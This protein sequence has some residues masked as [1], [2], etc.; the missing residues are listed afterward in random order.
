M[1]AFERRDHHLVAV[2]LG[3][4]SPGARDGY[5]RRL[6][7]AGFKVAEADKG[8]LTMASLL[9]GATPERE[10]IVQE[11]AQGSSDLPEMTGGVWSVQVG[12]YASV[13]RATAAAAALLREYPD[14]LASAGRR[15]RRSGRLNI[16]RFAGFSRSG[17]RDV[18][19]ELKTAGRECLPVRSPKDA[20]STAP[21]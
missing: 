18:C 8:E 17:A 4:A 10:A 11:M 12:A 20:T 19:D 14:S 7:E 2:V 13:S 3:G 6:V 16:V 5:M 21:G 1:T 9:H 15:I